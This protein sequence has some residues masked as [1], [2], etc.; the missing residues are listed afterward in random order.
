M[1]RLSWSYLVIAS[2][3]LVCGGDAD[4][5]IW[6]LH[7]S[8]WSVAVMQMLLVCE[9]AEVGSVPFLADDC[10]AWHM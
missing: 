7:H 1:F 10:L 4:G 8:C 3:V 5:H 9:G 2:L 6:S